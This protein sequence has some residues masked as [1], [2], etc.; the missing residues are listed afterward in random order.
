MD[1]A[2]YLQKGKNTI[3]V[4]VMSH[5]S[6]G[7]MMDHVPGLTLSLNINSKGQKQIIKTDESWLW[8][9]HTRYLPAKQTWGFVSD[10]IDARLD[11]GDWTTNDYN[12]TKWSKAKLINGTQWGALEPR[13]I[14]L[15]GQQKVPVHLLHN[16]GLPTQI[17]SGYSAIL[18]VDRMVQGFA[19][20]DFHAYS[21]DT[22]LIEMG[23]TTDSTNIT[24]KNKVTHLYIAKE[25]RQQYSTTDSY[26][27]HFIKFTSKNS[28]IQ[29]NSVEVIDRR[30]PYVEAGSFTSNDAFLNELWTRSSL[31]MLMNSE[32][33]YMDCALRE[34]T[35]WMGDAA[36]VQYPVSRVLFGYPD[37]DQIIRSDAGLMK[38]MIR[39]IAQSQTDS[40]TL[41]AHHPSDRWDI[42]GYIEDYSCQWVQSLRQVYDNTGDKVLVQEVWEHLKKQMNWF[43]L[44]QT[45]SG[46]LLAREF[47][48][49]DNPISYV[50]C[51]G[52]TLN[53][54]Y[55]KALLDASYLAKVVADSA[56]AELYAAKASALIKSYNQTLWIE[57]QKTYAAGMSNGK[58]L[59]P[60][61]HAALLALQ[62]GIVPEERQNEVE[63]FLLNNYL[64][65]GFRTEIRK[66]RS[67]LLEAAFNVKNK[68]NGINMPYTSFWLL[69]VL[70]NT[71]H[72]SLALKFIRTK[73][74]LMMKEK[75]TGTLSEGFDNGDLCHNFGA[76]P[77]YF[78]STKVLGASTILPLKNKQIQIKPQ[79]GD[80]TYAEGTVVT[81]LGLVKLKWKK[82]AK[83]L[84]F[85]ITVPKGVK[86]KVL[87][88][89]ASGNT[90]LHINNKQTKWNVNSNLL[91]FELGE[92]KYTGEVV[93]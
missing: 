43:M 86:A 48:I 66:N 73:W 76:V 91:S 53:A 2:K 70:Y 14:P 10:H 59:L 67:N 9:N 7:K 84:T 69:D 71:H 33:G 44:H 77:A 21:G 82:S 93:D 15:L 64:N 11:D 34:K 61:A 49:F 62:M 42:H 24:G 4:L 1:I 12:D 92:G 46:L 36:V 45:T 68:V 52:A 16:R 40:G 13:Q 31:T 54:F 74:A 75:Q 32:D 88:P 81:E 58:Q 30:Y 8:N 27:F 22:I 79:L 25:G 23:Y 83:K 5:G 37:K 47:V 56:A 78:L 17:L 26:G 85:S 20:F 57:E 38:N 18:L 50:Y 29:F 41:K 51:E 19:N 6:N 80:L 55:Y 3:A 72:D 35:E 39:H 65:T 63:L 60:T 28:A 87:L 90:Q 89:K